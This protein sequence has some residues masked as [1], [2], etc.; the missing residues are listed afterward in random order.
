MP[1]KWNKPAENREISRLNRKKFAIIDF[2]RSKGEKTV[3]EQNQAK[4]QQQDTREHLVMI[5]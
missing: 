3:S 4:E 5:N 1:E 2:E